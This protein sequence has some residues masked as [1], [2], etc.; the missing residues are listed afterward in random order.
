MMETPLFFKNKDYNLFGI[1]HQPDITNA[2]LIHH[3]LGFVFCHPFAEEKLI[4]HRVMVNFA[5][6][7][8]K[9]GIFFFR[10]DYMGHGD[11]N[12]NFDDAT[13]ETRLSDI[14]CAIE[15]L[16]ER[17]DAKRIGLLGVRLGATLA[18]LTCYNVSEIDS[19][20]LISPI[21]E[22]KPYIDQCLRSNLA[23]QMSTYKKIINDRKQLISD[24]MAGK[25]VNI[26]G[27]SLTKAL[28]QQIVSINLLAQSLYY[29]PNVLMLQVS[30][31][32]KQP[33]AEGIKNLFIKYKTESDGIE[34]LNVQED[35]FWT[36]TKMYNPHIRNIE[37]AVVKWLRRV[38]SLQAEKDS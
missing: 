25:T 17:T 26:D 27:Y 13:I 37:E 12:G 14:Q 33:F 7:L 21:V 4:A 28:Y 19:L 36:D 23:T 2:S 20:I 3:N 32:E 8:A 24:L 35:Y 15:F 29:P 34:L 30:M 38:Y 22:G 10:F 9:E 5:R 11:S 18:A 6:R 16:K 1:L 31:K